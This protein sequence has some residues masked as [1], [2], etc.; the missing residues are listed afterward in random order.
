MNRQVRE[1]KLLG[2]ERNS[3]LPKTGRNV[4][5]PDKKKQAANLFPEDMV[6]NENERGGMCN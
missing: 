6:E 1:I 5:I 2:I 4:D 3:H